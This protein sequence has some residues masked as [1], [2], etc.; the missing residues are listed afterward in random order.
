MNENH[1]EPAYRAISVV[2][3]I[4]AGVVAGGTLFVTAMLKAHGFRD[5]VPDTLFRTDA[6]FVR[7]FGFIMLL[8][9]AAWACLAIFIARTATRAW[10]QL[11]MLAFGVAAILYGIYNYA[12]LGFNPEIF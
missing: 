4:Q 5:G 12:F 3:L 2:V 11:G 10:T 1:V 9:P 6:L 7:R 8:V